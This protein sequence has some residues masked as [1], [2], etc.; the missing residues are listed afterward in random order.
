MA[1]TSALQGYIVGFAKHISYCAFWCGGI[2]FEHDSQR[3]SRAILP[4]A[5]KHLRNDW[6]WVCN[7][8]WIPA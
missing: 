2:G 3:A 8:V 7:L 1:I 6:R 4:D 5:S